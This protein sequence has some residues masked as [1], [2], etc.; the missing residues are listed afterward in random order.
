MPN[1]KNRV[2]SLPKNIFLNL[3][4]MDKIL[5]KKLPHFGNFFTHVFS[6]HLQFKKRISTVILCGKGFYEVNKRLSFIGNVFYH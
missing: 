3:H 2:Y 5:H 4:L 1:K 6:I